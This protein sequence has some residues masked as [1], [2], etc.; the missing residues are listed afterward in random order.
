MSALFA[1]AVIVLAAWVRVRA[2]RCRA[3]GRHGHDAARGV[4]TTNVTA[5]LVGFGMFGSFMLIP[6]LVADAG[7]GRLRLRRLGDAARASSCCPRPRSMLVAGPFAGRLATR[8]ARA[9]PL[10]IGIALIGARLRP[11]R[12]RALR[13]LAIY[14]GALLIGRGHRPLVRGHGEPD[15]R[16]RAAQTQT[17]VATGMNTIMRTVGGALGAQLMPASSPPISPPTDSRPSRASSS[18]SSSP[19]SRSRSRSR[20]PCSSHAAAWSPCCRTATSGSASPSGLASARS[21]RPGS[22]ASAGCHKVVTNSEFPLHSAAPPRPG[23]GGTGSGPAVAARADTAG[24][25]H[26]AMSNSP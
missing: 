6:Q 1:G 15:R 20:P 17:G 22:P 8:S 16:G 24:G 9:V 13:A 2:A 23:T 14:V 21:P 4:W 3:A 18:P 10:L 11:A 7:R 12:R 25:G 19:P 26:F 5:L